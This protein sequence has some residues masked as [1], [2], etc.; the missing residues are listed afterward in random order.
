MLRKRATMR[1]A[2]VE[3]ARSRI[4]IASR[5]SPNPTWNVIPSEEIAQL[6]EL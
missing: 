4:Q 6:A 3:C 1:I 5:R 2:Q